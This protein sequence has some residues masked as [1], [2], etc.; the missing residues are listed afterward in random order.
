MKKNFS[1]Q[2]VIVSIMILIAAFSRLL[3]NAFHI[4]NFTPITAMALFSGAEIRNKRFAF[5]IPLSAMIITDAF[6][7]F[8]QGILVV[9]VALLVITMFGFILQNRVSIISVIL[10]SLGASAIFFLVTNF[11]LFYPTMLYPHTWQGI[12]SSYTAGI[13]FLKNAVI[14]DLIYSGILFGS[15]E[16]VL[17]KSLFAEKTL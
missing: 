9:Y 1:R 7:G 17:K 14:G 12:I 5:L 2:F 6:L 3:T 10:A 13:P 15:Y 4:W 8:Y 16:L 11:A